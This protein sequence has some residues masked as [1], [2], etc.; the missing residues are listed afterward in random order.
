MKSIT[1]LNTEKKKLVEDLQNA[2][3]ELVD[4][5]NDENELLRVKN[6]I[7]TLTDAIIKKETEIESVRK[8]KLDEKSQE[9]RKKKQE[10][11]SEE[12]EQYKWKQFNNAFKVYT[13]TNMCF[14]KNSNPKYFYK[15]T[16]QDLNAKTGLLS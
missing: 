16:Y 9:K 7:Q 12:S 11:S 8:Q 6:K 14:Y 5:I 13:D 3:K 1:L 10:E 15:K 4:V 2:K